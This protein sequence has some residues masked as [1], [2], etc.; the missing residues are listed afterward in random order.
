MYSF[1]AISTTEPP[2]SLFDRSTAMETSF[3]ARPNARMRM[4]SRTI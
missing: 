4:G 3:I 1:S 2:T